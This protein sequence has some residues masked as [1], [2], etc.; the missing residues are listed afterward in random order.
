MLLEAQL[1]GRFS[2]SRQGVINLRQHRLFTLRSVRKLFSQNGFQIVTIVG[3]PLPYERFF[4][5]GTLARLASSLHSGLIR[6][7]KGLFGYQFLVVTRP[8]PSLHYLLRRAEQVAEER[9]K[10]LPV[11]G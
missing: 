8:L 9:K 11:S 2:Y 1:L 4:R 6:V 7:W 3:V 5:S 10:E